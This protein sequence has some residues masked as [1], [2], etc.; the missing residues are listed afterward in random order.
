MTLKKQSK[1]SVVDNVITSKSKTQERIS[2]I[3][4]HS[5]LCV[6]GRK[7]C[8]LSHS[9]F[10]FHV[11]S[12]LQSLLELLSQCSFTW[13]HFD[14][15]WST[16][17]FKH[18]WFAS[19]LFPVISALIFCLFF[20]ERVQWAHFSSKMH[21]SAALGFFLDWE[22][23]N[24]NCLTPIYEKGK[25]PPSSVGCHLK[26]QKFCTIG[27]QAEPREMLNKPLPLL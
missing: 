16:S 23:S 4:F 6:K 19:G 21:C 3:I 17:L 9:L 11:G 22:R 7:N 2:L 13:I 20:K 27:S 8:G 26:T 10:K 15:K 1:L 12:V 14:W 18:F 25:V 24:N 5:S